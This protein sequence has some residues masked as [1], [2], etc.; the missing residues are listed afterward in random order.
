MMTAEILTIG[1]EILIGQVHNTN[2]AQIAEYLSGIGVAITR[3]TSVGDD[4]DRIVAAFERAMGEHPLTVVTGGLGPTHDDVTR[5]AACTFF[6]TDLVEDA[7]ALEN[8]RRIFSQ[9]GLDLLPSTRAQALVPRGC[10]VLQN[11]I[12]TAPGFLFD[13]E[14]RV[15]VILP[16]VPYEMRAMMECNVIPFLQERVQGSVIRHRTIRTTGIAESLLAHRLGPVEELVRPASGVTLA[17]LPSPTGVRLR[18]TAR[19]AT[20]REA[21]AALREAERI[22]LER[23]GPVVYGFEREEL[24]EVVGRMLSERAWT[25]AVAESCTG[26]LVMDRLTNVPGSSRYVERG[27]VVYSNISKVQEL[28]VAAQLLEKHGAVSREVAEAMAFGARMRA[29]AD[30]GV[31]TTGIAGPAGGSAEKPVGL[32]WI[33]YSDREETT[34]LRFQ[35]GNDRRRVKERASQAALD[36]LRRKLL[37]MT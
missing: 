7:Q 3:M 9:R 35:F 26:G 34:A 24:E 29:N 23:A 31:S 36:V 1:D 15:L 25:I 5:S 16:G 37:K 32:V 6:K 30:I 2:Q 4:P 12:G 27:Y 20:P 17:F 21:E 33:G 28:G 14:G 19:S 13:R 10:T 8:I 11:P 22:I 18:I